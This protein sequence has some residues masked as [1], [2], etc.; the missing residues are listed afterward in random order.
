MELKA[1]ILTTDSYLP[2][3]TS[4][5]ISHSASVATHHLQCAFEKDYHQ[6]RAS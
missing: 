6:F 5:T 2:V 1:S 3:V 4:I